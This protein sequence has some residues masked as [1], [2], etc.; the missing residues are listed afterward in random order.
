[1]GPIFYDDTKKTDLINYLLNS[2]LYGEKKSDV[3]KTIN[4]ATKK[5]V[6]Q[7]NL[8]T[9]RNIDKKFNV[10]AIKNFEDPEK[11]VNRYK[12]LITSPIDETVSYKLNY[13]FTT[14]GTQQQ[15]ERITN[16]YS[17]NNINTKFDTFD[18]KIK[19]N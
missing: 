5:C 8:Y 17:T 12:S 6:N 2:P 11:R 7:F 9:K 3:E 18:G 13:T 16:L 1:M 4:D 10:E 19:F 14:D 15:K